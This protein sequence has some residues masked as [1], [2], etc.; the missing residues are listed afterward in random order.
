MLSLSQCCAALRRRCPL[1]TNS[2]WIAAAPVRPTPI[3]VEMIKGSGSKKT[4]T[5]WRHGWRS[6]IVA[7]SSRS[8]CLRR[9]GHIMT[10]MARLLLCC[11]PTTGCYHH[12]SLQPTIK[13][14]RKDTWCSCIRHLASYLDSCVIVALCCTSFPSISWSF[15]NPISSSTMSGMCPCSN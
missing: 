9:L 10:T 14:L 12:C 15:G 1:F 11:Y 6:T 13:S 4:T 3:V 2:P 5:S 7:H 8:Y